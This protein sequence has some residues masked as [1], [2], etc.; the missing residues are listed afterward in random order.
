MIKI[1]HNSL[2]QS[3]NWYDRIGL[4]LFESLTKDYTC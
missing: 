2:L 4:N 3:Y 1:G